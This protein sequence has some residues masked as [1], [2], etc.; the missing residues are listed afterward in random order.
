MRPGEEGGWR[1]R[2]ATQ[3][4]ARVRRASGAGHDHGYDALGLLGGACNFLI[5]SMPLLVRRD[6]KA[7]NIL[8]SSREQWVLCDFGSATARQ[9]VSN[10][11]AEIALM[12]DEIQ[13]TTTPA[14]RA[15]EVT[16]LRALLL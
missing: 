10:T 5:F 11:A 12:E 2:S 9:Q 14:Y 16:R 15:P 6:I 1:G 13:K 3:S 8:L 4:V 7:E